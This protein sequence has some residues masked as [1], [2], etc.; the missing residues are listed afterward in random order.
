MQ[1]MD[2][3]DVAVVKLTSF[4]RHWTLGCLPAGA[5]NPV[6]YFDCT[7]TPSDKV[8]SMQESEHITLQRPRVTSDAIVLPQIAGAAC[9]AYK[10]GGRFTY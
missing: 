4:P 10:I 8:V 2:G 1:A 5:A 7:E 9:H 3:H 6:D